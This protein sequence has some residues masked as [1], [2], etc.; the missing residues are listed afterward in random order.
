MIGERIK[1]GIAVAR[2]ERRANGEQDKWGG[3]KKGVRKKVTVTQIKA[4]HRMRT[5]GET[6][7]DIAKALRLSRPT[8]YSVLR[9]DS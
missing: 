7:V 1:E 2:A 3:S 5:D 6:V 8:I 9:A 4:I